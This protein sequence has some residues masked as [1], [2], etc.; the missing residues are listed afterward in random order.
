MK[1]LLSFNAPH[2]RSIDFPLCRSFWSIISLLL[3]L[4]FP[5]HAQNLGD[6]PN[7]ADYAGKS[8]KSST[9]MDVTLTAEKLRIGQLLADV[10]LPAGDR[11]THERERGCGLRGRTCAWPSTLH[12]AIRQAPRFGSRGRRSALPPAWAATA[13]RPPQR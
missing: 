1:I 5:L 10:T 2:F 6:I 12:R 13:N 9:D 8:W 4:Q 3:L 11:A 7:P